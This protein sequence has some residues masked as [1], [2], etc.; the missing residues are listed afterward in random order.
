MSQKEESGNRRFTPAIL[1]RTGLKV[2][3][4]GISSSFGAPAAAYEEA[5]ERGC[6]YINWGTFIKGRAGAMRTAIRNLVDRGRREDMVVAMLTY[7]HNAWL[8]EHY[9]I[10]GLKAAK[11]DYA[12]V[13]LLGWFPKRPPQK[14]IDGAFELKARGLVRFIGLTSHNRSLF[15]ELAKE[16]L[17]DLFHIRYNAAHRGAET[18][19]FP[20]LSGA[21]RPGVVSFTATAWRKLLG[22]RRL[23][24]GERPLTAADCYRF[25]LSH[26]AVDVCMMGAKNIAQMRENL[27]VLEQGPLSGEEMERV[28]G[29]GKRVYGK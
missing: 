15:P 3:R 5:F 20:H 22:T 1:G 16:G 24:P 12:D 19:T 14:V 28:R 2:G 25:V 18:E 23:P 6:N 4:L 7:A 17:F 11:L 21:D 13:L 26:P 10:K 9:F 8:T 29:I 27:M